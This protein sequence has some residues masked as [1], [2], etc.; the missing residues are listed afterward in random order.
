MDSCFCFC[1]KNSV[2]FSQ[3]LIVSETLTVIYVLPFPLG[4]TLNVLGAL[5][6]HKT[7][8]KIQ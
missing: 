7:D 5:V 6:C 4:K 1:F 3:V 8:D 2:A